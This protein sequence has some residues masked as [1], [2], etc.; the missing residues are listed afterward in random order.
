MKKRASLFSTNCVGI[1]PL[2]LFLNSSYNGFA[3]N[4]IVNVSMR[5][6]A[7]A[8]SVWCPA[9]KCFPSICRFSPFAP[10]IDYYVVAL[11]IVANSRNTC[12]DW[13]ELHRTE[14]T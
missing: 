3:V 9:I 8:K 7:N 12:S 2:N 4:V 1:L 11:R 5:S 14:M 13:I 6:C 10:L